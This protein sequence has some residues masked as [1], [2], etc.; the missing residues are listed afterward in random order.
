ME[1]YEIT[2]DGASIDR[3]VIEAANAYLGVAR[4]T[5]QGYRSV[6]TG[7]GPSLRCRGWGPL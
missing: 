2:L 7:A 6:D 4:G 5:F 1:T 3:S